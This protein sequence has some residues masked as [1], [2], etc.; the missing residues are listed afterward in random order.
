V[1]P[2][3]NQFI[4]TSGRACFAIAAHL[5]AGKS[6]YSGDFAT[7]SRFSADGLKISDGRRSLYRHQRSNQ[8]E[9]VLLDF[10]QKP[11][12]ALG[13]LAKMQVISATMLI[14]LTV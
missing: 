3:E 4:T 7:A 13:R 5:H 11:M 14:S 1:E 2:T 10:I 6:H 9:S 12:W 8:F